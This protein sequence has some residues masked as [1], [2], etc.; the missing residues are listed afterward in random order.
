M[1]QQLAAAFLA[2]FM[3]AIMM[4][5]PAK[6]LFPCGTVGAA[7]WLVYLCTK[8]WFGVLPG[9]FWGAVAISLISH[10]YARALKAPVTV[11]LVPG[12]LTLVPG[13]G[14]YSTAYHFFAGSGAMG[15]RYLLETIQIAGV[16]ALGIFIVDSVFDMIRRQSTKG[17]S[18]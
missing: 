15:E 17:G 1:I 11:F 5:V 9:N 4:D 18:E 10:C 2:I 13:A 16:I 12:F 8:E 6:Y 7:G 3:F 14:L